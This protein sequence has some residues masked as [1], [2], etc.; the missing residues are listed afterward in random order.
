MA[1]DPVWIIIFRFLRVVRIVVSSSSTDVSSKLRF[2]VFAIFTCLIMES[3]NK[4]VPGSGI[5]LPVFPMT[6][7]LTVAGWLFL[8]F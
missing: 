4:I 3:P 5:E 1:K 7:V 8:G 2:S 6:F